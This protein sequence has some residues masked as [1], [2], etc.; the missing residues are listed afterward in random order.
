MGTI[1]PLS[2]DIDDGFYVLPDDIELD[3][4]IAEDEFPI[5]D[6]LAPFPLTQGKTTDEPVPD[7]YESPLPSVHSEQSNLFNQSDVR[8]IRHAM[9]MVQKQELMDEVAAERGAQI[10][11][12]EAAAAAFRNSQRAKLQNERM[13]KSE[14][15]AVHAMR[16]AA[17]RNNIDQVYRSTAASQLAKIGEADIKRDRFLQTKKQKAKERVALAKVK[18][19]LA[20]KTEA[21]NE[22]R[23]QY[24]LQQRQAQFDEAI[25]RVEERRN[26]DKKRIATKKQL[27]SS[28][29]NGSNY[30]LS[31]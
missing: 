20:Q 1:S 6:L 31:V 30:S 18:Q 22:R 26:E 17:L 23:R 24:L 4:D 11:M 15:H 25:Q 12:K 16:A 8:E 7:E 27:I 29:L 10:L 19:I 9:R 28:I 2:V 13:R 21:Q 3:V 5:P 14:T